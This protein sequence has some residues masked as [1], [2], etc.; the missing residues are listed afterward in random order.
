MKNI[1]EFI[2]STVKENRKNIC[3]FTLTGSC[4]GSSPELKQFK[5]MQ[6][7]FHDYLAKGQS[8]F[9]FDFT[10]LEF[11]SSSLVGAIIRCYKSALQ[12]KIPF[13]V[14]GMREEPREVFEILG[15]TEYISIFDTYREAVKF[16]IS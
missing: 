2:S 11:A 14:F 16:L 13:A 1:F 5:D 6:K 7:D 3:I 4:K 8:G 9:I 10:D 15:C 12:N